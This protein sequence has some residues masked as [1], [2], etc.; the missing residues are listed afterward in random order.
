MASPNLTIIPPSLH[1]TDDVRLSLRSQIPAARTWAYFDHSAVSPLPS[2]TAQAMRNFVDQYEA[3]GDWHWPAWSAIAARLRS[4]GAAMLHASTNEI[5]LIP[6]TTFGINV[7]ANGFRWDESGGTPNVVI[8]ENEFSSNLLPWMQLSHRGVEVRVV[9]VDPHGV[10]DLDRVRSHLDHRTQLV[11][12]SWVGYVSGYRLDLAQLSEMVHAVGAQLF[13]DAIQGLGAFACDVESLRI[14][15]LAADGHKWMLGP[16]GAG[17]LYIRQS[18]LDRLQ[19]AMLGWGSLQASHIFETSS[20]KIKQDASRYEGG[21][22][23]HAGQ[24]GLER[25]L[26]LLVDLGSHLPTELVGQ[27]ILENADLL[28][29][30]L[31]LSG[32]GVPSVGS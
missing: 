16:E 2:P 15:Y 11:S 32:W 20:M 3:D 9:P 1:T 28:V 24:I 27:T 25:S 21:S 22:A 8:L 5:A 12:A 18:N 29:D 4:T 30:R 17:L 26:Q 13:V 7:V 6:N 31:R 14:D 19:P 10:V 23:N